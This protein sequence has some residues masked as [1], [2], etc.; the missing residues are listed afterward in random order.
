MIHAI[1]PDTET[2]IVD[3]TKVIGLPMVG[4]GKV[5]LNGLSVGGGN[6][7]ASLSGTRRKP[8]LAAR[9]VCPDRRARCLVRTPVS[10]TSYHES[11]PIKYQV[12]IVVTSC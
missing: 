12:I 10:C 3:F 6:V 5:Y 9:S 1:M 4:R 8:A 2:D 7:H 11:K